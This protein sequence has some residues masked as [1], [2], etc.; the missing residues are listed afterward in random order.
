MLATMPNFPVKVLDALGL[1]HINPL[2]VQQM[3]S[4][5]RIGEMQEVGWAVAEQKIKAEHFAWFPRPR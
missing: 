5:D 2:H 1:E 4:V 3:D